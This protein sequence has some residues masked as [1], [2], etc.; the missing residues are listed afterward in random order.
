MSS[1]KTKK[2][3]ATVGKKPKFIYVPKNPPPRPNSSINEEEG[4]SKITK[5]VSN[6]SQNDQPADKST[7]L[8][9]PSVI[10]KLVSKSPLGRTSCIIE[11]IFDDLDD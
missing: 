11:E 6:V 3:E 8:D 1:L 4:G 7:I 5:E 2:G 10:S 9:P